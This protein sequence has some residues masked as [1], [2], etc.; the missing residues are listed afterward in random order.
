[1]AKRKRKTKGA[2]AWAKT[3]SM[4]SMKGVNREGLAKMSVYQ[5][6]QRNTISLS[7]DL[8]G[9]GVDARRPTLPPEYTEAKGQRLPFWYIVHQFCTL[10]TGGVD[11]YSG[12]VRLSGLDTDKISGHQP[13]GRT[14]IPRAQVIEKLQKMGLETNDELRIEHYKSVVLAED[15]ASDYKV[16]IYWEG[17]SHFFVRRMSGVAERSQVFNDRG[18]AYEAYHASRLRWVERVPLTEEHT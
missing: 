9:I 12:R 2:R 11:A 3:Y 6:V 18:L 14:Q 4:R 16:W 15:F 5:H 17:R 1:M 10:V 13:P 7:D 8:T